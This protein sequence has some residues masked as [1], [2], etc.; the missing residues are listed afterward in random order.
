MSKEV[1]RP[2]KPEEG[3]DLLRRAAFLLLLAPLAR[4]VDR[5]NLGQVLH[6]AEH[7]VTATCSRD[8]ETIEEDVLIIVEA[9]NRES[10]TDLCVKCLDG[11]RGAADEKVVNHFGDQKDDLAG[12]IT[13]D[14]ELWKTEDFEDV[15]FV[16]PLLDLQHP[17]TSRLDQ[18]VRGF[19]YSPDD[20]GLRPAF[21][22]ADVQHAGENAGLKVRGLD[23]EAC[24][25]ETENGA[26]DHEQTDDDELRGGR[27]LADLVF[28]FV[29]ATVRDHPEFQL[30]LVS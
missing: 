17:Q 21:R 2:G 5:L 20:P 27:V 14:E 15:L 29:F 12:R 19:S 9:A 23:V 26:D 25:R 1:Q 16:E 13:L 3:R 11:R 6:H 4:D 30:E 28:V 22:R 8:A 24:E 10:P 18:A 7:D